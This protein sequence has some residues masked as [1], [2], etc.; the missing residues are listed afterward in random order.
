MMTLT[1]YLGP[2]DAAGG[3]RSIV[4]ESATF[5]AIVTTEGALLRFQDADGRR[6]YPGMF[7][8]VLEDEAQA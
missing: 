8:C 3:S 2:L 1:I 7:P 6:I 4:F 5:Q